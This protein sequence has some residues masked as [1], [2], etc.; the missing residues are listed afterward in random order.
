MKKREELGHPLGQVEALEP[1]AQAT[2]Q[3][4]LA[5]G[6]A[7]LVIEIGC[8]ELPPAEATAAVAQLRCQSCLHPCVLASVSGLL[9]ALAGNEMTSIMTGCY[10]VKCPFRYYLQVA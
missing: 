5:T 9:V 8:E 10:I 3:G 1:P 7:D 4:P 6:P 2:P